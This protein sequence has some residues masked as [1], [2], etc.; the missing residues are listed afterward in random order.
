LALAF[1]LLACVAVAGQQQGA[2][3][4]EGQQENAKKLRQY[5]WKSRTEV[6]KGG[7]TKSTQLHLVRYDPEGAVQ[8]TLIS[9][10]SQQIPTRGLRGFIA[11]KKKEDFLETLDGLRAVAKS[12]GSLAPEKMQRFMSGASVAPEK[13]AERRNLIRVEGRDVLQPGDSMTVWLDA[14][15]RRQRRVEIQTTFD[16]KP[17]R[18]VSEFQDLTDGPTHVARSVVEYP[19]RELSIITDNFDYERARR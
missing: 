8:Q 10:T 15:T 11:K 1:T 16:G 19:S 9:Q 5:S 4:A 7:E 3:F 14:A 6:R 12:Y 13:T 2:K 18:I 17:V